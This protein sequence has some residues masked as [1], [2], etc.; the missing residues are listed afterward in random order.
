MRDHGI[1]GVVVFRHMEF[2]RYDFFK[3]HTSNLLPVWEIG[4]GVEEDEFG[5]VLLDERMEFAN[6][7]R[8]VCGEVFLSSTQSFDTGIGI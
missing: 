3:W 8:L 5:F 7:L 6:A 4:A 1:Y 2:L